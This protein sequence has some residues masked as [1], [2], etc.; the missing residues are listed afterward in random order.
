MGGDVGRMRAFCLD[1]E[2]KICFGRERKEIF[3]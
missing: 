1:F 2:E 3:G